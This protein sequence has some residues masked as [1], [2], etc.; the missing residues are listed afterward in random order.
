[1]Q[2]SFISIFSYSLNSEAEDVSEV[3]KIDYPLIEVPDGEQR[4]QYEYGLWFSRRGQGKQAQSYDQQLKLVGRFAS[5][6]QFWSYYSH[7]SRPSQ[8]SGHADFHLFKSGIKPMWEDSAN[9]NGGKWIVR[10]R[11][12]LADRLWE[13]LI[14]AILGEQ[15]VVGS[16]IC[17]A[18]ISL[19]YQEDI[20]SVWNKN[21][22]DRGTT[23][24]I[25]DTLRRV[26]NLPANTIMEYKLHTDSLK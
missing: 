8:I 22:K 24:R 9:K 15:F 2:F 10:L 5:V 7:I 21:G 18:V 4:L 11:K 23:L 1:M 26:L 20:I 6:E 16:E 17:G 3:D 14:L 12:G 19:R 13:N 25:Q